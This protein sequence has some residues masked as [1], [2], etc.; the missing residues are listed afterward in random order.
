VCDSFW[1][2]LHTPARSLESECYG[3]YEYR[4]S[5]GQA[6]SFPPGRASKD[7]HF[8]FHP[9]AI[10]DRAQTIIAHELAEHQYNGDHELALIA[11]PETE[12]PI[13]HEARELL[14]QRE[15]G[16]RTR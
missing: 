4:A 14:R 10:G 9:G 3:R 12:L 15:R 16:W 6:L 11:G 7:R 5:K 2:R 8:R 1:T 13:S